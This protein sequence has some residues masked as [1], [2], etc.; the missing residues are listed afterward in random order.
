MDIEKIIKT[1]SIERFSPYQKRYPDNIEKSFLLYQSNIEISQAF[2]SNLSILEVTLRNAI[3]NSMQRHFGTSNWLDKLPV[4][5]KIQTVEIQKRLE[6]A[7]KK[8]TIDRVFAELNFGFWTSMFNRKYAKFLWKPLLKSFPNIPHE[9]RK[10]TKVSSRLN[11][12]R[13]FRNRIY[14]YEP[15]IWD[16]QEIV[17]KRKEIF[18]IINWIEPN[19]EKWARQ[20]DTF[21]ETKKKPPVHSYSACSGTNQTLSR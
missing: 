9:Y 18:S 11:H 2:Y 10:R 15:I 7:N 5:L 16:I 14:H 4:D 17:N 13:T 19:T 3:S 6:N 20:I 12:I 21:K 1:I 8:V